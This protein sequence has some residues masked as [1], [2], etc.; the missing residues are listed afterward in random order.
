MKIKS[1]LSLSHSYSPPPSLLLVAG[2][3]SERSS[4]LY[5]SGSREPRDP[6]ASGIQLSKNMKGTGLM[7]LSPTSFH[8]KRGKFR[9]CFLIEENQPPNSTDT[10]PFPT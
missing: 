1:S 10:P 6:R 8:S 5:C 4:D 3:L 7:V 2:Y 9:T